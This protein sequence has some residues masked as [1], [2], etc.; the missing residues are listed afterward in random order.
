MNT[1]TRASRAPGSWSVGM[2]R[3]ASASMVFHSCSVKNNR[4]VVSG[5]TGAPTTCHCDFKVTLSLLR[6]RRS[7]RLRESFGAALAVDV[8]DVLRHAPGVGHHG[9]RGVDA[10]GGWE[11]ATV[12]DE[13]V[14]DVVALAPLVEHRRL[15]VEAHPHR[16]V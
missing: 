10:G 15:R 8:A 11:A 6:M 9:Q 13:Q 2:M 1:T 4:S 7:G 14:V 16:A 12:D 5:S 3:A